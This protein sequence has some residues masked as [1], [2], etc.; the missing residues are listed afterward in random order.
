MKVET[1]IRPGAE[2][3]GTLTRLGHLLVDLNTICAVAPILF[4]GDDET[5]LGYRIVTTGGILEIMD[6]ESGEAVSE[7]FYGSRTATS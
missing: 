7:Y 3:I 4:N 2:K 5:V 6:G 1:A